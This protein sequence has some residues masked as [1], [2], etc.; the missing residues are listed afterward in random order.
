MSYQPG[1]PSFICVF[2]DDMAGNI[3]FRVGSVS[4]D[5]AYLVVVT[6]QKAL[7]PMKNIA[8]TLPI[9]DKLMH[10]FR[11]GFLALAFLYNQD[12]RFE[13]IN[14]KFIGSLL[15]AQGGLTETERN[16]FLSNWYSMISDEGIVALRNQQ[17]IQARG[18]Q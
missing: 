11:Y 6:Y 16:I 12:S 5:L 17:S 13:A 15:S 3:T 2:L 10:I 8:G 9:P 7:L 1:R 4:P 18:I 14:Q